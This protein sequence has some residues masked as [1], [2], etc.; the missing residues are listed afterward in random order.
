MTNGVCLMELSGWEFHG[1]SSAGFEVRHCSHGHRRPWELVG[2]QAR[3]VKWPCPNWPTIQKVAAF[4]A[5]MLVGRYVQTNPT[6][7]SPSCRLKRR[8]RKSIEIIHAFWG[9]TAQLIYSFSDLLEFWV[10]AL[11]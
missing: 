11:T 7:C 3:K 9:T 2:T 1:E 4:L 5:S 10:S 6:L 8:G